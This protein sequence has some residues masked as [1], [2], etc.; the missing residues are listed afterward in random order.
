[1]RVLT[2]L[3]LEAVRGGPLGRLAQRGLLELFAGSE[4]AHEN[5]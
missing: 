5:T 1:V 4:Q 3:A 2:D